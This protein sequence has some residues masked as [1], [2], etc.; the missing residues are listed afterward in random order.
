[1]GAWTARP[2]NTGLS[3][4]GY[5]ESSKAG[6]VLVT[7]PNPKCKSGLSW[8]HGDGRPPLLHPTQQGASAELA[9]SG[10]Q[11]GR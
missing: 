11:S 6:R 3:H 8:D 9:G 2:P 4:G 10:L 1:M 5:D 7:I